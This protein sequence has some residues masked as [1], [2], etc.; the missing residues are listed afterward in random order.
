MYADYYHQTTEP[1]LPLYNRFIIGWTRQPWRTPTA[2]KS[3]WSGHPLRSDPST[4]WRWTDPI[5]HKQGH[6]HLL[7][8]TINMAVTNT[9]YLLIPPPHLPQLSAIS[10]TN[11]NKKAIWLDCG[12]HAREWIA[13][14][15]C[16]WFVQ[17]VSI[18][19]KITLIG[20]NHYYRA[21][22]D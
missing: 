6:K 15:F 8:T 12:I 7:F 9:Y 17:Y 3:F 16:L 5:I 13:P 4:F 18:M 2:S 14:A 10:T 1:Y 19:R 20:P 21:R 11:T 22:Q